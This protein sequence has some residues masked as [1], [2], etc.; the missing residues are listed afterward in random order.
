MT[1]QTGRMMRR[2]PT[3]ALVRTTMSLTRPVAGTTASF[4]RPLA[5][6]MASHTRPIVLTPSRDNRRVAIPR[7]DTVILLVVLALLI[8]GLIMVQS[9]SEFANPLD[10]GA[11]ARREALWA[12]LGGLGLAVTMH[13]DYHI[14]H[15]I[16]VPAMIAAFVLQLLVLRL[17]ITVGGAQRWLAFGFVTFQ[18]SEVAKLAFVLFA[19][20]QL[21]SQR[22]S[23]SLRRSL[24]LLAVAGAL[25]LL[26]LFQND[27]GTAMV[28]ASCLLVLLFMSNMPLLQFV[29]GTLIA[30]GLGAALIAATPFRRER[31]LAFLHPLS[32]TNLSSYQIRQSLIAI[33]D[34]GITGRGLGNSIQKAG[35]LP[36]PYT[37]SIYAVICEEL[38]MLGGLV[39]VALMGVLLWRGLRA[40]W[41]ANDK[42][43][44]YLA[45][46]I[47]CW[48]VVQA[49]L[50][51]GSSVAALPF[52]GVPLPFIS[53]GGS[54]LVVLLAAIGILLN[55]STQNRSASS[56]D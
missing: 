48:I 31:I 49:A 5:L 20:D 26:V 50:N 16:A 43:G 23:F 14:W 15:R 54:S 4:T 46:G 1:Q 28:I 53:F 30:G 18:P 10:P 3:R 35:F 56:G 24:P 9:A 2:P 29:P 12:G 47:T 34:G 44:M 19:A 37:D 17:G 27:L 6:P 45:L 11:I 52:T 55:I 42:F 22:G 38:G 36:T 7:P 33:G 32:S 41:R 21:A 8:F 40:A 39:V 25:I 13:I 51:I